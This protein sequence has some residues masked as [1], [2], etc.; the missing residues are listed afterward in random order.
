MR[1]YERQPASE[2]APVSMKPQG[3]TSYLVLPSETLTSA[4]EWKRGKSHQK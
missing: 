1:A 2:A 4:L 3:D